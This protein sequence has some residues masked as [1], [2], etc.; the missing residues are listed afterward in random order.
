MSY[1]HNSNKNNNNWNNYLIT[2]LYCV[3]ILFN[4]VSDQAATFFL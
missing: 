2:Q 4:N 3:Y 1:I